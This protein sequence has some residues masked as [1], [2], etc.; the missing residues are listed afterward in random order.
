M[1]VRAGS[2]GVGL[3]LAALVLTS[4]VLEP[5][6]CQ[7]LS[8][9]TQIISKSDLSSDVLMAAIGNALKAKG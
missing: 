8:R 1:R 4:A 2:C 5:E 6:Q 7:R 3:V 9:A